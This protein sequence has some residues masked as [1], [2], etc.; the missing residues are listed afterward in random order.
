MAR[1]MIDAGLR[2]VL[3]ARRQEALA[4]YRGN[5]CE[6]ASS[7]RELAGQVGHVGVCVVNDA[8]VK[9]V[10]GEA[11]TRDASWFAHCDPFDSSS[12]HLSH[13]GS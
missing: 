12:G 1:R 8:D 7:L 5:Q 10:C 4:P 9:Q 3:W 2:V 11:H 13:V 6:F